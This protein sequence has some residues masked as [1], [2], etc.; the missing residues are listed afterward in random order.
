MKR[1]GRFICWFLIV[2]LIMYVGNAIEVAIYKLWALD[3]VYQ[4]RNTGYFREVWAWGPPDDF[5]K[6]VYVFD[7]VAA[8]IVCFKAKGIMNALRRL[9]RLFVV[10]TLLWAVIIPIVVRLTH[11]SPWEISQ[12]FTGNGYPIQQGVFCV[13]ITALLYFITLR[14]QSKPVPLA[15][16]DSF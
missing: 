11:D 8:F 10:A 3:I 1:F 9:R 15:L 14:G 2:I 12:N 6:L 4:G 16:K 13:M 7:A 5:Y